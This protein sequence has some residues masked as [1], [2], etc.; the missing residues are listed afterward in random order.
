M[1]LHQQNTESSMNQNGN[2]REDGWI[3]KLNDAM[4]EYMFS[5]LSFCYEWCQNKVRINEYFA[6]RPWL[7]L[8]LFM[9][10]RGKETDHSRLLVHS[11]TAH[12]GLGWGYLKLEAEKI[13]QV[14]FVGSKD[15][16]C[17]P[18][19]VAFLG[20][21]SAGSWNQDLRSRLQ[22]RHSHAGL[23]ALN[24]YFITRPNACPRHWF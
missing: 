10:L 19:S 8:F 16:K 20:S 22:T 17:E 12:S 13:I 3:N 5:L 11:H 2:R 1:L 21:A 15:L 4:K 18:S 23:R 6:L 9:Y 7:F 24:C 14:S